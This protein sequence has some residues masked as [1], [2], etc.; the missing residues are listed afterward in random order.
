MA[1]RLKN[2]LHFVAIPSL[3]T[4]SLPHDLHQADLAL[5]P[6]YLD[7]NPKGLIVTAD[8]ISVTVTN[9]TMAPLDVEVLCEAW[10][11]IERAFGG[12]QNRTLNPQPYVSEGG[13]GGGSALDVQEDGID[14]VNPATTLN[15][16][17][18][19]VTVT[20]AGGGTA[21]I[22]I[23]GGGPMFLPGNWSTNS[24]PASAD[25]D[26]TLPTGQL[27]VVMQRAGSIIGISSQLSG[28]IT[29]GSVT[30]TVTKNGAPLSLSNTQTSII[31]PQ[32]GFKTEVAEIDTYV[33]G[34][35]IGVHLATSSDFTKADSLA[36]IAFVEAVEAL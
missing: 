25:Q 35:V 4:A 27:S 26:L 15:F 30:L 19:G 22:A 36:I 32:I 5:I 21:D 33:A 11:S 8:D 34:D 9:T 18:G 14:I 28:I 12:V 17:G 31:Q 29:S 10:H 23:P 20:D 24:I 16:T 2:I 7:P 1:D 3:G 6:D 13:G